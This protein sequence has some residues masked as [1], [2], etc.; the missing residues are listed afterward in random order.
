M[1][2][3]EDL[4]DP[5]HWSKFGEKLDLDGLVQYKLQ[6]LGVVPW[7]TTPSAYDLGVE[8]HQPRDA[9]LLLLRA[10]ASPNQL[11]DQGQRLSEFSW[12]V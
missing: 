10:K 7:Q 2:L 6:H 8:S 3:F 1:S 11:I 9:V 5:A 12:P 4:P